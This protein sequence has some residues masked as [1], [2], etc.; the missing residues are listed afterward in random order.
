MPKFL[1]AALAALML[2][3]C[4]TTKTIETAP[5]VTKPKLNL[6]DP[7]ALDLADVQWVVI[8]P[9]NQDAVFAKLRAQG[10]RA[11][12]F[13][14]TDQGYKAMRLNDAKILGYIKK[15]K[16]IIVAYRKYYD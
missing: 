1:I 14:L 16:G 6:K 10:D 7:A 13:A 2:A 4:A 8:T 11:V 12:L 9:E 15:Q 3:G 5:I